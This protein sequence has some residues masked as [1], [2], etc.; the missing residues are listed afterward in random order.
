M[1]PTL[2]NSQ[3]AAAVYYRDSGTHHALGVAVLD[4]TSTGIAR[5]TVFAGGPGLVAK[6]G[7]PPTH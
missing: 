7:L 5:I 3:P 2:A 1:I 6:F 4:A